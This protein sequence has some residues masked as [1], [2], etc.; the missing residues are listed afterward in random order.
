[1]PKRSAGMSCYSA[2]S[3]AALRFTTAPGV[4]A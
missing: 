3:M 2:R 4:N 1:M